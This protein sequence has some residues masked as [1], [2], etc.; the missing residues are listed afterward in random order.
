MGGR[1]SWKKQ[2]REKNENDLWILLRM[3]LQKDLDALSVIIRLNIAMVLGCIWIENIQNMMKMLLHSSVKIV[4]RNLEMQVNSKNV[5]Y[6]VHTNNWN[7]NVTNVI[8]GALT[9]KQ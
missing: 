7:L 5:W 6:D 1:V 8:Y 2:F 9:N 3:K 4:A